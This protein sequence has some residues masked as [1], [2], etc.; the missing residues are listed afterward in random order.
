MFLLSK[1][2]SEAQIEKGEE[3]GVVTALIAA[4]STFGALAVAGYIAKRKEA[5]RSDTD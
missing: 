2:E 1:V 3:S 4:A 5:V